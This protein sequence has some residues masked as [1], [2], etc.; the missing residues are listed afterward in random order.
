MDIPQ[1]LN[2]AFDLEAAN[3]CGTL[4]NALTLRNGTSA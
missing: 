4:K 1:I 3:V 2:A